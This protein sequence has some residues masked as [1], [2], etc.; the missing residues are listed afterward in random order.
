MSITAIYAVKGG[1]FSV[2]ITEFL[3]FIVMTVASMRRYSSP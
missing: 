1:M 2:V 3:Q